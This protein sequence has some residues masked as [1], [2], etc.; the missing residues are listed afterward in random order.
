MSKECSGYMNFLQ[1]GVD[2][3]DCEMAEVCIKSF[4]LFCGSNTI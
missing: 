2:R 4:L 3:T 1:E